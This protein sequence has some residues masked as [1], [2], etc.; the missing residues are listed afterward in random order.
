MFLI[1]KKK[2]MK[3]I[4]K[5]NFIRAEVTWLVCIHQ[6]DIIMSL[7]LIVPGEISSNGISKID[8]E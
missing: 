4:Q 5:G 2:K 7:V 8:R 3:C 6:I 1:Y